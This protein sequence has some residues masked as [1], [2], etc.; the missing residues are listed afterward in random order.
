VA[1]RESNNFDLKSQQLDR[2]FDLFLAC[3]DMDTGARDAW[4][5]EKCRGDVTLQANVQKMILADASVDGFLSHS[6][7]LVARA[8]TFVI[9]EGKQFGRYTIMSF[10]GRGGMGEVWKAHDQ[11][12]DRPVALKF[13]QSG[14]APS[15]LTREARMASS[16]N[17]PGIVTVHDVFA[18]QETPILVMELVQGK[19]LSQF[20]KGPIPLDQL[21]KVASQTSSAL[22]A[23]HAAGIIHGDLKPDN[24]LWRADHLAKILDFGLARKI[25][26][27][28]LDTLGGT[29]LYMSPE[30]ARGELP[31]TASD[32]Y[33]LGLVLYELT[34]G[35]LPFGRH[36]LRQTAARR[37]GPALS[38]P[39]RRAPDALEKLLHRMLEPDVARRISMQEAAHQLSRLERRSGEKHVWRLVAPGVFLTF[40][41]ALVLL[42]IY[43]SPLS[44]WLFDS[45]AQVELSRMTVRPIASQPGFEDSPSLSPDG[46]WLSC[47]YRAKT[48]DI[49]RLQIHSTRDA[50]PIVIETGNLMPQGPAAWSPDSTELLFSAREGSNQHAIYRVA[51]TGGA[52]KRIHGCRTRNDSGCQMDWSP[53]G[54]TLAV[55][56]RFPDNS[57]LYALDLASGRRRDLITRNRMYVT[58]PRFSPDGQWV[59]YLKEPSMTTTEL[60]VVPTSGGPEKRITQNPPLQR[61]FTWSPD[62]RGLLTFSFGNSATSQMWQFSLD[63]KPQYMIGELDSGRAANVVVSRK[64]G[65]MAWVRDLSVNSLSRM[66][67]EGQKRSSEQLLSST[68]IDLDAEWS[69]TGR[70]VF[71]SDRSGSNELWIANENGSD[72]WQ[73]TRFRGTFV[74]DPHW[75][76][77]G[78]FVAFTAHP[79]GNADI[80]VMRCPR[81]A[82]SCDKPLQLTN[83]PAPDANPTWSTGG[84]WIYLSSSRSGDFEV[85]R[86]PADKAAE[87]ERL[88]WEGGYLAHESSDGNW[89]YFSK[90]WE[91]PGFW[92]IALPASGAGQVEIP[93]VL[94]VPFKAGATW[95]LGKKE[96]F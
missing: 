5:R 85:W 74:G 52:V 86:M 10:I 17:H 70:M 59:A 72:P 42:W 33:S 57:E 90:L 2:L 66:P 78:E 37:T 81:G 34:S 27:T 63:G 96:L 56:D 67:V 65:S 15:Q 83:S 87:P 29:P 4:L 75:S 36:T 58:A 11:E 9:S 55:A 3:R 12:L 38:F 51:R 94:N 41:A 13:I 8:F 39:K 35:Q 73:A 25:T 22:A 77:D 19:P 30:Q 6:A 50:R 93:V 68:A 26:G 18:W 88:T 79:N 47:L 89:L 28:A 43:R 49:P 46:L 91:V 82:T 84:R 54:K 76:P 21:L 31:G 48:T 53:D 14:F 71:R 23:A 44:K 7:E 69:R 62:G 20:C 80:F 45:S 92:R 16:L 61:G 24:I 1:N 60:F 40:C 95:A 32:V 64:K